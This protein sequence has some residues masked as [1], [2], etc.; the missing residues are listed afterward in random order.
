MNCRGYAQFSLSLHE[1]GI[2]QFAILIR[3]ISAGFKHLLFP[4]FESQEC[5]SV[6]QFRIRFPHATWQVIRIV[7]LLLIQKKQNAS[8]FNQPQRVQYFSSIY[9]SLCYSLYANYCPSPQSVVHHGT[10][11]SVGR[12]SFLLEGRATP[13]SMSREPPNNFLAPS[14]CESEFSKE[15]LRQRVGHVVRERHQQHHSWPPSPPPRPLDDKFSAL[16]LAI[17]ENEKPPRMRELGPLSQMLSQLMMNGGP[18]QMMSM[19]L[20]Q[21]WV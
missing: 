17:I 15:R 16:T 8:M 2:R 19:I 12:F 5:R 1:L 18:P 20:L 3:S 4:I 13:Y 10:I 6:H 7:N 11:T 21:M 14:S 9:S